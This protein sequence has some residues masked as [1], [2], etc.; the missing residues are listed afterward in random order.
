MEIFF[1][2]YVNELDSVFKL[3][4]LKTQNRLDKPVC[5]IQQT[6]MFYSTNQYVL[7]MQMFS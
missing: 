3:V 4:P 7:L 5:F 6:S 1:L 2:S